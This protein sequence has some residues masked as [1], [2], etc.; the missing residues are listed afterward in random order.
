MQQLS[1]ALFKGV[2]WQRLPKIQNAT[3]FP[4]IS[5]SDLSAMLFSPKVRGNHASAY[6][7]ST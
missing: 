7:K 1:S 5:I 6:K 3:P 4:I 2:S